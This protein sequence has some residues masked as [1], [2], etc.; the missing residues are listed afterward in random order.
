MSKSRHAIWFALTLGLSLLAINTLV[1]AQA[2]PTKVMVRAISRDAKVIGTG[3]GGV[4]ITI[5]DAAKGT[6]LAEGKQEGETG[7]TDLIMVQPHKRGATVYGTPGAAGFLATVMLEQPTVVEVIAEGPLGTPQSAQRASK[8]LLLV[9]G[10]DVVGEGVLLEIHGFT[11]KLLAP[12]TD[13]R[14]RVGEQLD[15][16][17]H[18]TMT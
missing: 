9:P 14:P 4:R 17:A 16:R 1:M 6:I 7:N 2:I 13:A 11:I 15:V 12:A 18:V 8:T 3:V 5:R 10:Q